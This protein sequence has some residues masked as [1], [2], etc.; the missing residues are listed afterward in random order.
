MK[1][2]PDFYSERAGEPLKVLSIRQPWAWLI[3]RP[4][5]SGTGRIHARATG[6]IKAIENRSWP[7]RYR[8]RVL[9]HAS[10][11]MTRAQYDAVASF[12]SLGPATL[13]GITL[14]RF[15]S[16]ELGGIVGVASI[17]DCVPAA[18]RRSPWHMDGQFGFELSHAKPLPFIECKGALGLFDPPQ[19]VLDALSPF[20]APTLVSP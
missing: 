15:E 20:L 6:E 12:L 16:L 13:Q 2:P 18:C 7:T 3:V 9:I 10:Q 8:A 17:T 1:T 14:P 5:L 19:H 11:R 4:D